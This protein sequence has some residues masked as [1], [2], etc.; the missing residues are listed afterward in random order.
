MA[1]PEHPFSVPESPTLEDK[2]VIVYTSSGC[3]KCAALKRLLIKRH[4]DFEEKSLEDVD[5]MAS[6]IMR[7][8]FILSAPALQV[9]GI[10]YTGDQIFDGDGRFKSELL[11]RVWGK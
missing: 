11:D 1:S 7:S 6:L 4:A 2:K 5:V 3:P 8:I 9:K 10:V